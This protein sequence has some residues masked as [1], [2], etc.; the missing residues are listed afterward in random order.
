[1]IEPVVM[2]LT[3]LS[4]S[5]PKVPNEI[6]R[7][8]FLDTIDQIFDGETNFVVIEGED[9]IGKTSLLGQFAK[10]HSHHALSV[11][12]TYADKFNS[13]PNVIMETI[14]EQALWAVEK[15]TYISTKEP[16]NE[17]IFRIVISHLHKKA[18][19][20]RE[21]YYFILDGLDEFPFSNEKERIKQIIALIPFALPNF[22]ILISGETS[23]IASF[24]P[25]KIRT[26][27]FVISGFTLGETKKYLEDV[28][29]DSD[30]IQDLF[31]YCRKLPSYLASVRR[32][33]VSGGDVS[34]LITGESMT[35]DFFEFE[36]NK[37][38]NGENQKRALALI[39]HNEKKREI[40]ELAEILDFNGGETQN[41][42]SN[43]SF[44]EIDDKTNKVGY[45]SEA[46]RKFA[47]KKLAS[48]KKQIDNLLIAN[49]ISKPNDINTLV[50]LP[51]LFD[52][53][54]RYEDLLSFLTYDHFSSLIDKSQ[55]LSL[56]KRQIGIGVEIAQKLGR[57]KD[58]LRLSL[59]SSSLEQLADA[60]TWRSEIE[61]RISIGDLTGA[62]AIAQSITL[63]EE[64]FHSL[65]FIARKIR[66]FKD[67]DQH[68]IEA[69][70]KVL[71]QDLDAKSLGNK[72]TDIASDLI[73]SFPEL[74]INLLEK[75]ADIDSNDNSLDHSLARLTL[76]ATLKSSSE[77]SSGG[78]SDFD[79]TE[80]IKTK[81]KDP[82][83]QQFISN[84]SLLFK[85]S[86][87]KSAIEEAE[88]TEAVGDKI[89]LLR[90]WTKN[91]RTR[92]DAIEVINFALNLAI[93][94]TQ[95]TFNATV[96]RE[97]ALPLP[98]VEDETLLKALVNKFD[99]QIP[100]VERIGPTEDFIR[101]RLLLA[102]TEAKYNFEDAGN[103]VTDIY[104][105]LLDIKDLDLKS[106]CFAWLLGSL[107]E[108]DPSKELDTEEFDKL[109]SNSEAELIDS[110]KKLLIGTADHFE[111]TK[112]T[113]N[114]LAKFTPALAC[115]LALSLNTQFRRNNALLEIFDSV[116]QMPELK[117][118]LD[119]LFKSLELFTLKEAKD[120]ALFKVLER[121]ESKIEDFN[122]IET[123]ILRFIHQIKTIDSGILTCRAAYIGYIILT[124]SETAKHEKF[125][126]QLFD[127]ADQS[128]NQIDQGWEKVN[129]GF[130]TVATLAKSSLPKAEEYFKKIEKLRKEVRMDVRATL[131]S[132]ILSIS[133]AIR[134]FA[135]LL[136]RNVNTEEDLQILLK[137][138][139]II[140][141]DGEQARLYS[142]L[143]ITFYLNNLHS[144]CRKIVDEKIKPSIDRIKDNGARNEII[145]DVF[146]SFFFAHQATGFD[147]IKDLSIDKINMSINNLGQVLLTKKLVDEPYEDVNGHSFDITYAEIVDLCN[148]LE[149]TQSDSLL[150]SFI[151]SIVNTITDSKKKFTRPQKADIGNKLQQLANNKLPDKNG[152]SHDGYKIIAESQ[153]ARLDSNILN[154][155]KTWEAFVE[156]AEKIPNIADR[157]FVIAHVAGNIPNGNR[158][159]KKSVFIEAKNMISQI[160][161]PQDR[162]DRLQVISQLN[163]DAEIVMAQ[164][165]LREAFQITLNT[166]NP[167]LASRQNRLVD[168]AFRIS[169]SFASSI[170][171]ITDDDPAKMIMRDKLDR[172][173]EALNVKDKMAS[174]ANLTITNTDK[175]NAPQA[176]WKNLGELNSG[177]I[178]SRRMEDL[179]DWLK[180][181]Y[182]M[183]LYKSYSIFALFIE[184]AVKR[185]KKTNQAITTL[186]QLFEASVQSVKLCGSIA[187]RSSEEFIKAVSYSKSLPKE[188]LFGVITPNSREEV[189]KHLK[190]WFSNN[191]DDYV[192]IADPYFVKEN[193][194]LLQIIQEV[195]PDCRILILT[196]QKQNSSDDIEKDYKKEWKKISAQT[197]PNTEI[198]IIGIEK[199]QASP[200][201]D[202]WI[203]TNNHGLRLGTSYNS[204]GEGK[205]SEISE[206][207]E[208]NV[209]SAESE[210]NNYLFKIKRDHEGK[211][212]NYKSFE[213][214]EV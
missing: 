135:G 65:A 209:S 64:R 75:A 160:T 23:K 129:V 67:S 185:Y 42:I 60:D 96:L 110:F 155:I 101:L 208:E 103:R 173:L 147:L 94:S 79:F 191:I 121:F 87:A 106:V 93:S 45:I 120:E 213:L 71:F 85:E 130:Q 91:N 212:I 198:T 99:S 107:Q 171:A 199:T 27:P 73:F 137:L 195:Q 81:V 115:K 44:I 196:S 128:W 124:N 78:K 156:R 114:A 18:Q 210:L 32:I 197:S 125:A 20:E 5:F 206:L 8:N 189:L 55:T 104:L 117:I 48:Y 119:F 84:M 111:I 109:H 163:V 154:N 26:K 204:I 180:L 28:V 92:P 108:I 133:L 95:Y 102:R 100:T 151:S 190:E 149:K 63:K 77:I 178:V 39:A 207:R 98:Y 59:Q 144:F 74:A 90:Q 181:T 76:L 202:R 36:W 214:M 139:E 46:F 49:L 83:L 194:D 51:L 35:P 31:K 25:S 58:L 136:P 138:I 33:I 82:K 182:E 97:L 21:T 52:E 142:E 167:Q 122:T 123:D 161:S 153:I 47:I 37:V 193:L 148:L 86:S 162:L 166:E 2:D 22:K 170:A 7:E 205:I 131:H 38:G 10:R 177:R 127:I 192:K 57:S 158:E 176:A 40:H 66:E 179:E 187:T 61:A 165:C 172:Q 88:K 200:I 188:S 6:E 62:L 105:A 56:I 3:V 53:T 1:M 203:I 211:R 157:I 70:L 34:E 164:E 29:S 9:G 43:L 134:A 132:Y 116:L 168:L 16:I 112:P 146:P 145:Q 159:Y 183:P 140:P 169:P 15:K 126:N 186:R 68:N 113:I 174:T 175:R 118:N 17:G 12:I 13:D 19:K 41:L 184:N 4:P 143:A 50:E 14:Y 89:F 24:I 80:K 141:S 201:H 54:E 152:V 30:T 69:E 11:F 72:A 150:F